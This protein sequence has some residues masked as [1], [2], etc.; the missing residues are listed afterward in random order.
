M[1]IKNPSRLFVLVISAFIFSSA[2]KAQAL[3]DDPRE[4]IFTIDEQTAISF[5]ISKNNFNYSNEID[6]SI[7]ISQLKDINFFSYADFAGFRAYKFY[8]KKIQIKN[9]TTTDKT[10][11]VIPGR[12]HLKSEFF[13][14]SKNHY[15]N[16]KNT[17]GT[18]KNNF[19]SINPEKTTP[20]HFESRNFTFKINAGEVTELYYKFQ[21]PNKSHFMRNALQF[22]QT[23][24]FQE[25]RRF[26]LWLEG[27]ILGSILGLLIFTFYSYSQIRDKTT[28]Y[29][30]LWLITAFF[31]VIGQNHH[32]GA[33]LL[34]FFI[35]PFED[36]PFF[37]S[38]S[39]A[40]TIDA[41]AGYGQA[42]MFVIFARN[43][44]DLKKYHPIAFKFTNIYL[45]WYA[46]HFFVFRL[47]NF[48]IDIRLVW[49][50]LI[51]ST[52]LIL[53]LLFYCAVKRYQHGM[54]TAK[55]FIIGLLPY[56]VFRIFF[57]L[58]VFFGFQSPFAYLPDSGLQ[59]F[60]S[61]SQV[62]QSVGLFI[63]AITM[64]LVLAKRTKFLQDEL[65]DNIQ[66]QAD[67]VEKQKVILE[68]TV[69]ERTSELREKSTMLEGISNQLAKYIPPQIHEALFAGKVDTKITTRRRKLT[70]FFSDIKNFTST[71]ENMQPEDL[72]KYLNE[73][74]SEMTKIAV[75]HGA[76]IDKY[77]GDSMMVFFGDPET[78][79]EKEDARTCIEMALEMQERMVELR[80]KWAQEGFAE[81]FEIRI[82]INTGYCNV[83]NFGSD[84]RL[85]YTIIGGEVN[86][87]A[88]L[89]SVATVN[90]LYMSY[91]TYAHVQDIVEVEQKEAIKMKGINRDI[92]IY[93]VNRRKIVS[94]EKAK[95]AEVKKPTKRELTEIEKLKQKS[96]KLE[97]ESKV[98]KE[99]LALI[100]LELKEMKNV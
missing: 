40:G 93:S 20:L 45:C 21:M 34:E 59:F 75:K 4:N 27:I 1:T 7:T 88:R 2:L 56:F 97:D 8:L 6:E 29:F 28:L 87:A 65:N 76:T 62:T 90:G 86:V 46:F 18:N 10:I 55:F 50:S 57:L 70:V 43:F 63:V 39:F 52:F 68:E 69:Q 72:T 66:N 89:E 94:Q 38:I 17:P 22:N 49:Y 67:E 92:R 81:P 16:F 15:K 31:A 5:S 36:N 26:G 13:L 82:G 71:S 98:L 3:L 30:G 44:I 42:M 12:S 54:V 61:S 79:G 83:G 73:Y 60:L 100:K 80:E 53:L 47:I 25:S 85:T 51:F 91:E 84:Q 64:S 95:V 35:Y 96:E 99:E 48:E 78:K 19:S 9:S 41:F 23:E 24:E 32:D 33:R 11:S 77:I 14:L 74:F 37:S 58:G